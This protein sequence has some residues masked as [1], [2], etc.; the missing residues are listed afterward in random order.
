[1][2]DK[3]VKNIINTANAVTNHYLETNYI[4]FGQMPKISRIKYK[5][6][7][8]IE[9]LLL[10]LAAIKFVMEDKKIE[11]LQTSEESKVSACDEYNRLYNIIS[12]KCLVFHEDGMASICNYTQHILDDKG[13]Q[14]FFIRCLWI[15]DHKLDSEEDYEWFSFMMFEFPW[16]CMCV[17]S[18]YAK[19]AY[20]IFNE[21]F[22]NKAP[23]YEIENGLLPD[24]WITRIA[25]EYEMIVKKYTTEL[26]PTMVSY[27]A[28]D[29][30]V[31]FIEFI[32]QEGF[33]LLRDG[34]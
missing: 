24:F 7:A 31:D 2:M 28:N 19:K 17:A 21:H 30:I 5:Q 32:K 25:E 14:L 20:E 12:D 29:S 34:M 18:E 3:E 15:S 13:L 16:W 4:V 8:F 22:K 10:T 11:T 1:M 26:C 27:K 33:T 9:T 23:N 6:E